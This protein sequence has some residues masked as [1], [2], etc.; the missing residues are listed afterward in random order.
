MCDEHSRESL[1]YFLSFFLSERQEYEAR[2]SEYNR[3]TPEAWR[4][5]GALEL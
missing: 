2:C 1:L 5:V 3:A 4:R